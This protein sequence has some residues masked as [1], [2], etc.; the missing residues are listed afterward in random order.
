[1]VLAAMLADRAPETLLLCLDA[2]AYIALAIAIVF[3]LGDDFVGST[4]C[5]L[6]ICMAVNAPRHITARRAACNQDATSEGQL[7]RLPA[8]LTTEESVSRRRTLWPWIPVAALLT[9][10]ASTVH[11]SGGG[12]GGA[13]VALLAAEAH[14]IVSRVH[15]DCRGGKPAPTLFVLLLHCVAAVSGCPGAVTLALHRQLIVWTY[16]LT[17]LRKLYCVG[18]KWM[19]GRNLQ[20]ML[21]IQGLYHDSSPNGWN[22][23]LARH[24]ALC[25]VASVAVVALQLALPLSLAVNEPLLRYLGFAA[26]MSFHASNHILWR[27]NFFAAW[28]PS[29]LA[30]ASPGQQLPLADLWHV[31]R[32]SAVGPALVLLLYLGM[33]LGHALDLATETLLAR[34]R[35]HIGA[36]AAGALSW[37]AVPLGVIWLLEMHCLGDYYS[38]YWPTTHPL[39]DEPVVCFVHRRAHCADALVPAPVDFYWRRDMSS[40]VR[41]PRKR[42]DTC[43]V[44]QWSGWSDAKGN[45]SGLNLARGAAAVAAAMPA[46]RRPVDD[47]VRAL[48]VQLRATFLGRGRE[49][50]LEVQGSQLLLCA[51]VLDASGTGYE[52]RTLWE[53]ELQPEANEERMIDKRV[54]ALMAL[55]APSATP[56][57]TGVRRR[58]ARSPARRRR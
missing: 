55:A 32:W 42:P 13:L 12:T 35:S 29:L 10:A 22:F 4:V 3:H 53:Y 38:S 5:Y 1:M 6:A 8:A 47:V 17:G 28:C 25:C 40:G 21:S 11:G 33:Q 18:P 58:A 23:V 14:F 24:R 52:L 43:E 44:R 19:D 9:A 45:V 26:A 50:A 41:W 15:G 16:F 39:R 7:R 34:C 46:V 48:A 54:E 30:L 49:A 57:G 36:A 27:I 37:R 56:T 20:L 2:C 31:G 51:R